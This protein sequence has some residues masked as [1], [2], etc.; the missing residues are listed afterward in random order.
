MPKLHVRGAKLT[1]TLPPDIRDEIA[2]L[3]GDEI[4]VH[5]EDGRIVLTPKEI[6]A[7]HPEIDAALAE[8]LADARAGRL[9]PAFE[10]AEEI[11]AWQKT[12][13]YKKFIG[14]EWASAH[15]AGFVD[16]ST[17]RFRK[18]G[19]GPGP[20]QGT[21]LAADESKVG[22]DGGGSGGG[23]G[24]ETDMNYFLLIRAQ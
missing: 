12:E 6:A 14:K 9:S 15:Y 1:G 17:G 24:D 13:E 20:D 18:S 3:D 11:E 5:T 23:G 10:T 2:S 21:I 19:V 22:G 8:G 4:E 16:A 7:R